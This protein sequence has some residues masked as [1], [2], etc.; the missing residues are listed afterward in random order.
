MTQ[1]ALK[2]KLHK[3]IDDI[4]DNNLLEAV[5]TILN[6]RGYASS[7]KLSDEDIRII[8]ERSALY[9]AGKLKTYTIKEARKKIMRGRS[10]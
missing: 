6:S 9:E 10:K 8:E 5:Y 7:F 3:A 4:E 1:T 2:K